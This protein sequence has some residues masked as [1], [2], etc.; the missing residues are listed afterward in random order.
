VALAA[1]PFDPQAAVPLLD[2]VDLLA[3]NGIEYAQLCAACGGPAA[4][5]PGL[6]LLITRGAEG[7]EYRRGGATVTVAAHAVEVRDTTGAGDTFL[8][9]FLAALD[10]GRG[11]RAALE[12][13]AAAAAIQ[14]TR[15]GAVAAIPELAEVEAFLAARRA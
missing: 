2:R 6:G 14:V 9:Y 1:A 13:A 12:L 11:E 8:G 5:P 10:C 3:V 15:P 7:A 4:L